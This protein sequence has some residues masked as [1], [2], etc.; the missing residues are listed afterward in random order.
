VTG[1]GE[2]L[3]VSAPYAPSFSGPAVESH[4]ASERRDTFF[5]SRPIRV[6]LVTSFPP[7]RGDLNEYGFHLARA[8]QEDLRVELVVLADETAAAPELPGYR[9]ERC[10]KFDS[11][12][13]PLRLLVRIQKHNPDVVWFNIGFSTFARSPIAAFLGILIPAL[14]RLSGYYTHVT[15]HTVFERI[16][17]QDAGLRFQGLYRMAGKLATRLTLA[18]NDVS[19]LLPSFR[20]DLQRHYGKAARNV[21]ARPHG[22]FADR[23][24]AVNEAL[25]NPLI[26]AFGYWGT[27]KRL[28]VLLDA[29]QQLR[30][31][32]P[33][34]KLLVAGTSHPSTPTYIQDLQE[35]WHGS[36]VVEFAGYVAE[37]ALPELFRRASVLVLPYSSAAGTSGVV[38][39]ACQY[40]VPMLA[41][42]IAE[43]VEI[44]QE[45]G[46]A[47]QF[48]APGDGETLT[49][50]LIELLNSS[51]LRK[52]MSL[53]NL[54]AACA[55]PMSQ[56]VDGYIQLFARKTRDSKEQLHSV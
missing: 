6:L 47:M 28:E 5:Y 26:L 21:Q 51:E 4:D 11:W 52:E 30:R 1:V 34:A 16:S 20:D 56:V 37:D 25:D 24:L 12:W 8:L 45:E 29:V 38:H 41:A 22:T 13:N 54:S 2:L 49:K 53:Q 14:T 32:V 36:D 9:I 23:P 33:G 55:T 42:G 19:V 31:E 39:Q 40:G 50:R 43:M 44:A 18:A 35:K 3:R 46:I 15:L 17:L 27:Y 10:W 7:S 48:Y